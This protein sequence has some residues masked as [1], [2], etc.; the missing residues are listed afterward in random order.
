[1]SWMR[2]FRRKQWDAERAQEMNAYLV[3]EIADNIQSGMSTEDARRAAHIKLGNAA[4]VREEIYKMNSLNVLET[5]WQDARFALRML[6]KSSGFT[7]VAVL[8]LAVGLAAN[9]AIFSVI[10]GVLLQ[11]LEYPNPAQLVALQLLVPQW[12]HKFP[13]VPLNPATYLVWSRQASSLAGIAVADTDETMNLTGA[14]EP[15]LLT[16]D[17][18]TSTLFDVLGVKPL[19]GRTFSPDADQAGHNHEAILT[20]SLWRNRFNG[21]PSVIGHAIALD[22]SPFVVVGILPASF[23]FPAEKELNP[24]EGPTPNAEIFVPEVFQKEDLGVDS[25]FGLA[26]IARLKPGVT[27]AEATAELNVILTREFG[28]LPP[29]FHPQTLMM[30]LRDMIVRSS[31]RGLWL[32]LA[33]VL[34]VLLIICVNLANLVLMRATARQHDAAI[35]TALG[36]SRG[37]LLRQALTETLL[38]GLLGG[39]LG[40]LLAYWALRGLLA[41][42]PVTLPRLH[43]VHLDGAVLAFTLGI[44][45]LAGVLAG[46]LPAWRASQANPHDALQSGG[47]RNADSNV[48]LRAR[49][50]LVGLETAL[51]AMLLIAAGL[52]VVSF[53]KLSTV[54]EGFAVD[55]I[56]T[57]NLQL[58]GAQYTRQQ[59]RGEFWKEALAATSGLP[60]VESS[61]VTN[62]LPLSGEINDDPVDL[63]GDTRPAAE[64]PFAS[65][66]RVSPD[67]FKTLGIPLLNGRALTWADAGTGNVVISAAA[68]ETFWP[69]RYPIGQKFDVYAHSALQ[70]VGVAG[71]ARSV[72]LVEAPTPMVYELEESSP[73]ASLILRTRLP[74]A[75][76]APELHRAI[77][78]IDPT[79]AIP[80]IRSM[81]QIV[82]ASLAPRRF[83]VL[84]TSLFAAAALLLACLGI[85]GVV[86]YS[87]VRRTQE[88]GIRMALGAQKTDVLRRVIRQGM[89]PALLG[90]AI[91]IIGA[92][93]FTRF[94]SSLLFE[95]K[96]TDPL[97]LI[98]V[99]LILTAV[100]A[101]ACYIPARR[102]MKVDPLVALRYE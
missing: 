98:A 94:L 18:V 74:A 44:S 15:A 60:G 56:L 36:A 62:F 102:A 26:T 12:E 85:Y 38:L 47:A 69:G 49:E 65:Y 43:N 17:A 6:R 1:M 51:S 48:R 27:H 16:A 37:R 90:L 71:D 11:P 30:P 52:L 3:T 25:G 100:A 80:S 57:V 23:D 82:S 67:Y 81:G 70:V 58:P 39:A 19:L 76:V 41:L 64:R 96:P 77:W 33:A 63:P 55:H 29:S 31:K 91:G 35:R 5:F 42:A 78:K 68:A 92:L 2:F 10:N 54:P 7:A 61:A 72:S 99:S 45:V 84:L 46:L 22:G 32:L 14:G 88:I 28:V 93:A 40:L 89:K 86:S 59:Q 73:T 83:E 9:T 13:M 4:R 34:A 24:V 66:R 75:A 95:V 87:V 21:D 101:L 79:I 53:A 50:F 8:T 97:T 20:Y